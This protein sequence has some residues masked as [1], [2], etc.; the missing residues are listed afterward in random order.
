MRNTPAPTLQWLGRALCLFGALLGAA[1]LLSWL[2]GS[3]APITIV[4][5]QLPMMPN[6]GLALLLAG[7]AGAL[8]LTPRDSGLFATRLLSAFAALVVLGIGIG[9]M[10][11]YVLELPFSI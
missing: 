11:E 1:G 6:T 7:L 10:A 9:T 3:G 5:S 8:L 4:P 2:T